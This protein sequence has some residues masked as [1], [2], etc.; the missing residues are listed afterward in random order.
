MASTRWMSSTR[1]D[2]VW[3]VCGFHRHR[4][5]VLDMK[6]SKKEW[7]KPSDRQSGNWWNVARR[8]PE[9]MQWRNN[10][11][12]E[13]SCAIASQLITHFNGLPILSN[14]P[15]QIFQ[16]FQHFCE[17]CLWCVRWAHSKVSTRP[18][19]TMST[20]RKKTQPTNK[21]MLSSLFICYYLQP[22]NNCEAV[23]TGV[24]ASIPTVA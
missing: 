3:K 17:I 7:Q 15:R 24:F 16:C 1:Q 11:F 4:V 5:F 6:W 14:F 22:V 19:L 10:Q 21:A 9:R 20:K 8:L 13:L 23:R 12:F 18:R 2:N